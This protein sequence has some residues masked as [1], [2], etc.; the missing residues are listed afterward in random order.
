M[1]ASTSAVSCNIGAGCNG[2]DCDGSLTISFD[3]ALTSGSGWYDG[4]TVDGGAPT[5]AIE[6]D[7]AAQY[8]AA[9]INQTLTPL[10]TCW[11]TACQRQAGRVRGSADAADL[12]DQWGAQ[13]RQIG[14]HLAPG[15]RVDEW[16]PAFPADD[17][18]DPGRGGKDR[19]GGAQLTDR[20]F[21]G[22]A[23]MRCDSGENPRLFRLPLTSAS[24]RPL[25]TR[26][27]D[28]GWRH[29]G[30]AAAAAREFLR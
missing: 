24:P 20:R 27:A 25:P 5:D 8:G 2:S 11:L 13:V 23:E 7:T 16:H 4:G 22:L 3:G 9:E 29:P 1:A 14:H 28:P 15:D 21:I 26:V 30:P 19:S 12:R 18:A 10:E 17:H 6:I